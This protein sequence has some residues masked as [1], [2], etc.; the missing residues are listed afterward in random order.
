MR[1]QEA[2]VAVHLLGEV[3][4]ALLLLVFFRV[5]L[6]VRTAARYLLCRSHIAWC[7]S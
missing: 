6:L 3:A 4:P 7:Y 5:V 1:P 2:L